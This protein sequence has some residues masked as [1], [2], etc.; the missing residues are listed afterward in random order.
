MKFEITFSNCIKHLDRT[1]EFKERE[2]TGNAIE[3]MN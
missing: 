2:K 3:L 1:T